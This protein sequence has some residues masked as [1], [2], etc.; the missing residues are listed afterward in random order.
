MLGGIFEQNKVKEKLLL[1]DKKIS[2]PDFW[3]N[4]STA[5]KIQ[6]EKKFFENILENFNLTEEEFNNSYDLLALAKKEND[7]EIIKDCEKKITSLLENIKKIEV[8]C[9]YLEPMII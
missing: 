1:F 9:F 5:L 4:Q 3:K 7:N 6:K 8:S 2:Q